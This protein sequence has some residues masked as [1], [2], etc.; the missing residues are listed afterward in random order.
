MGVPQGG[1]FS[2]LFDYKKNIYRPFVIF[3]YPGTGLRVHIFIELAFQ[4]KRR[5]T[6]NSNADV[7]GCQFEVDLL[8]GDSFGHL[9]THGDVLRCLL[10]EVNR[11]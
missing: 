10:P 9:N 7:V 3:E 2:W 1:V 4:Y 6:Q 5:T 11:F 8:F